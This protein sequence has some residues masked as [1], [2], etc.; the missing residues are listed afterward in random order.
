ML[1][2]MIRSQ[3]GQ[4]VPFARHAGVEIDTIDKG[5]ASARLPFRPEGLNHIGTQHAAA[6]FALGETASGAAMAGT[7]APMLLEV[8]PVAAEASI[9]YFG[10][11]KG[12]VTADARVEAEPDALLEAVRTE[13]KVRFPIVV[14][15]KGED[16]IEIGEMMVDWHVSRRR[17]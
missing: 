3:M 8:R 11:A 14:S 12:Q 4:N 5:R 16:G 15:L 9:R 13:G 2:D 7:F 17:G 6:L 10:L 1:Y